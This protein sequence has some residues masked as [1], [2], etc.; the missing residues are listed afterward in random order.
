MRDSV[1]ELDLALINAVQVTPRGSWS[2]L[3]RALGI[4]AATAARRWQR[5][6]EA[7]L[8]WVTCVLGPAR[9]SE[10]CMAYVEI[11]CVPGRLDEVTAALA[12]R[13]RIVY[14]HHLTGAYNLLA[15]L[16]RPTP[17][18]VADYVRETIEPLP[19]RG[20]RCEVR[21]VGYSEASRWRLRSLDAAQRTALEAEQDAARA[22]RGGKV[23]GT[24]QRLYRLLHEDGRMPYTE[25]A[26]R[27]EIS[28]P[29]A[30]R[31]VNRL[32]A[33]RQ[34]RLRCEVA[35]SISG[36]PVTA[37]LWASVPPSGLDAAGR[38]LAALPQVR[39][40][41]A[42]TGSRNLLL[43]AWLRSLDELPALEA[44]VQ[45]RI[46]ELTVVDRAVCLRTVK[47][48]GRLLDGEGRSV[49]LVPPSPEL[50]QA[51]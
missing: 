39:L 13:D 51:S 27:A 18:A 46:G 45:G 41:C 12:E 36:T 14:V 20:Y 40:C 4:D 22:P 1:D 16:A 28:E 10:F 38:A 11:D 6:H 42:L 43:M 49:R 7:G 35:Q 9:H 29:T 50:F 25:L 32:L 3:G 30:R 33:G 34:L 31:R 2:R 24:D 17:A 48:M 23:D 8:A 37:F 26:A 5:L 44:A 19:V 47:Q 15:V 21:T